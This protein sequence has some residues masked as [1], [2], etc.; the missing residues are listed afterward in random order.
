MFNFK[1]LFSFKKEELFFRRKSSIEKT[2]FLEEGNPNGLKTKVIIKDHETG[3][4]LFTGSNKTLISGSEFLAMQVFNLPHEEFITP[5]YN[6]RLRLDNSKTSTV[7]DKIND[8]FTYLFCVGTSGCNRESAIK[9]E[10][11]N[12]KWIAPADL[13]PFQYVPFGKDLD[14]TQREMYFGK[15]TLADKKFYAYY[16]KAFD[17]DPTIRRQ[18]EDGTPIDSSIYDD[19][20]ELPAQVVIENNLSITKDDCRDYF[21]NTTGINDARFNCLSLCMAWKDVVDGYTYYQDIRPITRINFANRFMNDSIESGWDIIY[22]IY[23]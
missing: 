21:I 18:L 12:K 19:S 16:F 3:L 14:K 5:T 11:S 2:A 23:F 9:Y 15:K 1:D 4:V 17:S 7:K 13:V 8:Y 22:R 20:S 6:T 10:V